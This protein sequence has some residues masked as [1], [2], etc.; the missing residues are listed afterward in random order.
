MEEEALA[1]DGSQFALEWMKAIAEISD[2]GKHVPARD[3][4]SVRC[5]L[6]S[7]FSVSRLSVRATFIFLAD[8][9]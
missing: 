3:L 4:T 2:Y 5:A 1:A 6:D 9:T 8:V 7:R